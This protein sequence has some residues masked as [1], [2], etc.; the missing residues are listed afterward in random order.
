[1]MPEPQSTPDTSRG[2]QLIKTRDFGLLW[3]GQTTS[4]IGEGLNKV[5]LLWFVYE[6]TG[7]AMKMTMVGLLQTIPPLL[8][9]PLIGVYL[10]RLPKKAVM[11]W[12]DLVRAWLTLLIPVLYA[13][14]T[15]SIEGL[16]GLIFLTS[17]VSTV[18]GP[19]LVS[20]VPLL[21]R[22]SELMS[23]NALIQGTTNI[24]MLLGPAI[25][26]VMIALIDAE[27]VLFVN[28]ATFLISALCLM[29]IRFAPAQGRTAQGASSLW[30]DLRAGFRFVFAQQSIVFTL[31]IIS[32]LYNLG[33]SAFVFILPVYA[34]EFLQVGP[35]QLGWLW[36][37]LG[38]GMLAASTWLAWRKH[39]DVQ[40][41]LR[42]VIRG[43][44]IGGLAVCSLSFLE[45]PLVAAGIVI[46]VGGSTAVLNPIV[47][48]L[49]QEVTPE[50][51]IGRVLTTFS[52]GSMASAMAGMTGFGWMADTIGPAASLV[53]LGV[54]LLLTAAVA[55]SCA[56]RACFM[57]A[58]RT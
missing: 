22:P 49:L 55:V 35:V 41:R 20:S 4:Q 23:A 11:V 43:M 46:V 30:A 5:A 14:G 28:S 51:L 29:P 34:K 45:T 48:A 10:D 50:H 56:R 32:S 54:V 36:S 53:G 52:V 15:L 38:V 39:S 44:T 31:V 12:V 18:F 1:M 24:G 6:L 40:G 37:A 3:G 42:I 58:V 19:A 26:G 7:S 27:N 16:Y 57:P 8:F 25:S 13:M 17:V 2:W 9:G 33:V 21:V 47:W